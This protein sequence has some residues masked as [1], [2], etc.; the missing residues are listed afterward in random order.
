MRLAFVEGGS[1][2][3]DLGFTLGRRVGGCVGNGAPMNPSLMEVSEDDDNDAGDD[4]FAVII[5]TLG[6]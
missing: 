6:G 4:L 5:L 3:S 1:F 2:V